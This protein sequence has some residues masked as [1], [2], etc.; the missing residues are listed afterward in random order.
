MPFRLSIGLVALCVVSLSPARALAQAAPTP[1][2][3]PRPTAQ[4]ERDFLKNLLRD[5]KAIW[6]SPTQIRPGD[7]W[8]LGTIAGTTAGLI[9]TDRESGDWIAKY[10]EL[11]EPS[12][13]VSQAGAGYTVAAAVTSFYLIGRATKNERATQTALLAG[14]A[15]LDS[16]IVVGTVKLITQRARPDSGEERSQFFVGGTSFPSGHSSN[17]WS[18][19][20]VVASEYRDKPIVQVLSYGLAGL[21]SFSRFTAQRHYLSDI[22]IGSA[23]GFGV[24]RYVY[25]MH[26]LDTIKRGS[27]G[28]ADGGT[29]KWPLISPRFDRAAKG[30][31]IGLTWIY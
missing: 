28:A 9:A 24:G 13:A 3:T 6:T 5:Q 2:Q 10:P 26:H 14:Q 18:F 16:W 31:S 19:A 8:W 11:V 22:L 17:V 29:G 21:I 4:L 27:G 30:Y 25:R 7:I 15:F 20:T 1:A 12:D 23:V